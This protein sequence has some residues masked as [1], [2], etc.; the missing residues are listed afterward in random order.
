VPPKSKFNREDIV[1]IAFD[2]VRKHGWAGLSARY[3]ANELNSSTMPIYSYFE[4]MRDLEEEVVRKAYELILGYAKKRYTGDL[5][6]DGGI[7]YVLFAR[8][9]KQ[10][11]RA[12][13]DEKYVALRG[14][15][16]AKAFEMAG[17][18]LADYPAFQGL[19]KEQILD[20]RRKRMIFAYGLA[21][22]VNIYSA[23][24]DASEKSIA[25][26][27]REMDEMLIGSA[28]NFPSSG[29]GNAP[30]DSEG[31]RSCDVPADPLIDLND[32]VRKS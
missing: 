4:S 21:S 25:E 1:Q 15:Y 27:L 20:I 12:L 17:H 10:L 2:A 30:S 7:G 8:K 32:P 6:L 22:Y 26:L 16:S 28:R 14:K 31:Q 24:T 18:M 13:M 5:W 29:D 3:I 11:F 19:S 23:G 9:E